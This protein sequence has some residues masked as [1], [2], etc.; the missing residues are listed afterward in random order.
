VWTEH[1]GQID[2]AL[3][4]DGKAE[5]LDA[6][7]TCFRNG[8]ARIFDAVSSPVFIFVIGLSPSESRKS[9]RRRAR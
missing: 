8:L 3:V 1:L 2:G 7:H 4:I 9:N 5:E 6:L